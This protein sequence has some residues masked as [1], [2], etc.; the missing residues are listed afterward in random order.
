VLKV[1]SKEP[2]LFAM[3]RATGMQPQ[4]G[5]LVFTFGSPFGFK[6]SMTHGIVSGLGR[7][8]TA[9]IGDGGFTNFIQTDAAVNPGNSGGPLV[10]IKGRIIGMNVAIATGRESQGTT[11]GQSAGISFSIPLGTIESVVD[12]L[13]ARGTVSRGYLGIAWDRNADDQ[14]T[15]SSVVRASGVRV[16]NVVPEGPAAKAGIRPGD[17]ITDIAGQ[18]VTGMEVLRSVVTSMSPGKE[19]TVKG[20]RGD[21]KREFTVALG[22]FPQRDLA[23]QAVF[24]TLLRFGLIV[25]DTRDG[26]VVRRVL[27][28]SAATEAGFKTGQAVVGVG[29]KRVDTL[30]ELYL[31]AADQ[32][33]LLGR[34]VQFVIEETD[35][36]AGTSSSKKIDVRLAH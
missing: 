24:G 33:I 2:G 12:Q 18:P 22:E 17:L 6:F 35:E 14:L 36:E 26:P 9:A 31:A 34:T 21:A 30:E 16:A 3:K 29:S 1:S 23:R 10:D 5:D 11:E 4:Q 15:Y 8:A 28:G 32:G 25:G 13:I 7:D 27:N 20:V 19:I